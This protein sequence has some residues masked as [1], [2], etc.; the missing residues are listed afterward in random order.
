MSSDPAF[1]AAILAGKEKARLRFQ[2]EQEQR[3]RQTQDS[4][5]VRASSVQSPTLPETAPLDMTSHIPGLGSVNAADANSR[6][7]SAS[8][9]TVKEA[10]VEEGQPLAPHSRKSSTATTP[11]AGLTSARK[12]KRSDDD[13]RSSTSHAGPS[14]QSKEVDNDSRQRPHAPARKPPRGS[15]PPENGRCVG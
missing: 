1:R 13:R 2:A 7:D 9:D 14:G 8:Y 6:R 5:G 4:D 11:Y 10:Q 3:T 12:R 15:R